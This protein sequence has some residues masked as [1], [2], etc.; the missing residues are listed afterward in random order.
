V[1]DNS[2]KTDGYR[3]LNAG[4][5]YYFKIGEAP[6]SFRFNVSNLTN[7]YDWNVGSG[8]GWFPRAGR[9]FHFNLA[10]DF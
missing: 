6:A 5:R 1:P 2:F 7:A 3:Q 9:R 10:A 8:G 4:I